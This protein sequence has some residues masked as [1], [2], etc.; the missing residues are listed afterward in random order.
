MIISINGDLQTIHKSL[1]KDRQMMLILNLENKYIKIKKQ[2]S[3]P[4]EKSHMSRHYTLISLFQTAAY[5]TFKYI[6][7]Y[8]G[9][10][11][12]EWFE[13]TRTLFT[14]YFMEWRRKRGDHLLPGDRRI[15]K[16]WLKHQTKECTLRLTC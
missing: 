14:K 5:T 1:V 3:T 13:L 4:T 7:E 9:L 16:E 12:V 15:N 6:S 10:A 8:L 11:A 2:N